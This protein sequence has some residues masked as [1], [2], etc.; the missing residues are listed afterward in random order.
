[1]L[2]VFRVTFHC[3][4]AELKLMHMAWAKF[5]MTKGLEPSPSALGLR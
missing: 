5:A 2:V 1:M 4:E 3:T